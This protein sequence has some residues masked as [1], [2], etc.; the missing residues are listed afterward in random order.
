MTWKERFFWALV[1]S[2]F[3]YWSYQVWDIVLAYEPM[4]NVTLAWDA[5]ELEEGQTLDGYRV[6]VGEEDGVYT[7]LGCEADEFTTEC[8]VEDLEPCRE[9]WF[10]ATA[11]NEHGESDYSASLRHTIGEAEGLCGTSTPAVEPEQEIYDEEEDDGPDNNDDNSSDS[12]DVS[13]SEEV[14][15]DESDME[16]GIGTD[17]DSDGDVH[18][19]HDSG[20]FIE[21]VG[22][23]HAN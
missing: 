21:T 4:T 10:A 19:Q 8:T 3:L 7:F 5:P 6:W 14:T 17:S 23:A 22:G 18:H 2:A 20:C 11:F 13:D 9:Y 16:D 15:E 1:V 12:S